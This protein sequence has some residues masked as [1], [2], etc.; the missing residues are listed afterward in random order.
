M[1][2]EVECSPVDPGL[3]AGSFSGAQGDNHR[4]EPED[5]QNQRGSENRPSEHRP[6]ERKENDKENEEGGGSADSAVQV[7]KKKVVEAPPPK[8]NPWTKRTANK[9]PPSK[10][11][12]SSQETGETTLNTLNP[13]G[14]EQYVTECPSA[15]L[16]LINIYS[17]NHFIVFKWD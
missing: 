3:T 16:I 8:V 4:S 1:S 6:K 15:A 17:F 7:V 5:D 9:I 13:G 2:A 14:A 12:P 10:I 11:L